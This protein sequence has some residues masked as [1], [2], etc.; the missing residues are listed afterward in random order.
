M[1]SHR[2]P[3]HSEPN[4]HRPRQCN[5]VLPSREV[6]S[7]H[8]AGH[9][10]THQGGAQLP[11]AIS[12]GTPS[13]AVQPLQCFCPAS[14]FL[15]FL[16]QE[17]QWRCTNPTHEPARHPPPPQRLSGT[18]TPGTPRQHH[19]YGEGRGRAN[20]RV[21]PGRNVDKRRKRLQH[22]GSP[23][24]PTSPPRSPSVGHGARQRAGTQ[25]HCG[26]VVLHRG[27][28]NLRGPGRPWPA[29]EHGMQGLPARLPNACGPAE[30]LE[31][32]AAF[33]E[34]FCPAGARLGPAR[35]I[36]LVNK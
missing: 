11:W 30:V 13:P 3:L 2:S 18:P 24:A 23:A 5:V 15:S 6:L 9:R 1:Q 4:P 36:S 35:G 10:A 34:Y 29:G 8:K 27:D 14:R 7:I 32:S 12:T 20:P 21:S 22:N 33:L 16:H 31:W 26:T 25:P 28:S 17:L 19:P